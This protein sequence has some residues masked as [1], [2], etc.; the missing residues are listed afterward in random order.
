MYKVKQFGWAEKLAGCLSK[1]RLSNQ[2]RTKA[3][4]AKNDHL[5]D[6]LIK[7]LFFPYKNKRKIALTEFCKSKQKNRVKQNSSKCFDEK[8]CFVVSFHK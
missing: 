8:S 5:L 7:T 6:P 2:A 1:Q 3:T 4:T